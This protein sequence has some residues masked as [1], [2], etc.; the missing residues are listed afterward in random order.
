MG[1]TGMVMFLAVVVVFAGIVSCGE[2]APKY[3]VGQEISVSGV[4]KIVDND[5]EAYVIV[6]E[7]KE[8]FDIHDIK[9]EYKKEGVPIKAVI[10][11]VAPVCLHGFG[12]AWNVVKYE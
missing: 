2:K 11:V 6:T 5:G 3:E 9:D 1:K 8:F 10:K 4:M 7:K 12:P